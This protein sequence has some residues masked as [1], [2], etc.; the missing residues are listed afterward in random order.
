MNDYYLEIITINNKQIALI[1][2][3]KKG[4]TITNSIEEISEILKID[5]I[6]YK[7]TNNIID[8]WNKDLGFKSLLN[9]QG[10]ICTDF[11]SAVEIAKFK[12]FIN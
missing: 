4:K 6:I 8:F 7:D 10:K 12:N 5:T 1:I 2:D 3:S 11:K 9:E